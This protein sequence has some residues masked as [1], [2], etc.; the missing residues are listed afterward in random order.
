[1]GNRLAHFR[2]NVGLKK[3]DVAID[4]D[5]PLEVL[6]VEI[7]DW[8]NSG[9]S[10]VAFA[11]ENRRILFRY[12]NYDYSQCKSMVEEFANSLRNSNLAELILKEVKSFNFVER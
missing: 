9:Y 5:Y 12:E 3:Y 1:L 7:N 4:A 8:R 10:C 11:V 2:K 6:E